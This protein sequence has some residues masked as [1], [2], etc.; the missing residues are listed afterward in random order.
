MISADEII[1]VFDKI[2][3]SPKHLSGLKMLCIHSGI[4]REI[5]AGSQANQTMSSLADIIN[6]MKKSKQLPKSFS[7][8][9]PINTETLFNIAHTT[10]GSVAVINKGKTGIQNAQP[11]DFPLVV[12]AEERK[13]CKTYDFDASAAIV[14][15]VSSTGHGH[16][17]IQRLHYQTGK[18]ALG[19]ILAAII[20]ISET[21]FSSRFIF[22]YLS[23]FK[24]ELLVSR[25]T[26]TANVTLSISKI[27][28][29]P[30]PIISE[31][32]QSWICNFCEV[33]DQLQA[34]L[35]EEDA[36][37]TDLLKSLLT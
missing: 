4:Q 11:G 8:H 13:T 17:S 20:P 27:S 10:I 9:Q 25:M 33:C 18:F 29:I 12:T 21:H 30:I 34:S 1:Q 32:I 7:S 16:A 22:E 15:L 24:D 37:K 5:R 14:P 6:Q 19:T 2:K 26:G 31:E 3:G 28:E 35:K 36:I 23:T